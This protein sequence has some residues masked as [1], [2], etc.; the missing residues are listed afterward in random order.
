MKG[1]VRLYFTPGV[2]YC[3]S[4]DTTLRSW[5]SRQDTVRSE[6]DREHRED[7]LKRSEVDRFTKQ[8]DQELRLRNRLGGA[9]RAIGYRAFA[10]HAIRSSTRTCVEMRDVLMQGRVLGWDPEFRIVCADCELDYIG[11]LIP[12][13][14]AVCPPVLRRA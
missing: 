7:D 6:I 8:V 4:D 10:D 5:A 11:E 13:D 3:Y 14:T 1:G 12:H 9:A 2:L